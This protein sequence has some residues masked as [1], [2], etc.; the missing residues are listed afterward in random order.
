MR[1]RDQEPVQN[2]IEDTLKAEERRL[3]SKTSV[4]DDV[5]AE[6]DERLERYAE[7]DRERQRGEG[8]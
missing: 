6:I 5:K 1:P 4:P 3:I 7:S 8:P 2:D